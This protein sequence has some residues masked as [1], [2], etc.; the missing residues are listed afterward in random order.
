MKNSDEPNPT[1]GPRALVVTVALSSAGGAAALISATGITTEAGQLSRGAF[2][3]GLYLALG[4]ISGAL[5]IPFA[6]R[7]AHRFGTRQVVLGLWSML[8]AIWIIAG[9]LVAAGA[10]AMWVV[11]M[12]APLIGAT[13]AAGG[14]LSTIVY[15]AYLGNGDFATVVARMTFWRGVGWG[16]GA[17]AGGYF[18]NAGSEG[19]GLIAAGLIKV[20]L[21]IVLLRRT[22]A[23]ALPTPERPKAPWTEIR[24]A[25]AESPALRRTAVMG[26]S[27]A[28]FAAPAMT[29]TVPIAQSL[30][31][32][33]LYQGAGILMAGFAVG[34]LLSPALVARLPHHGR[35]LLFGARTGAA[36]GGL[37]IVL[38]LVS[39]MFSFR[40]EL[41]LWAV[42]AIGIGAF[43][44][45]SKAFSQSS[46]ANSR[47]LE[48]SASS[49]AAATFIAGLAGPVGV[50]GWSLALGSIGA[51]G[52]A[53][54]AGAALT[55][56][57]L[58]VVMMVSRESAT[59]SA[60]VD[61]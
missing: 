46:A 21:L 1:S 8:A 24:E 7:A 61:H 50:L 10:P 27:M 20:P 59:A 34:E 45:A 11:M 53:A 13:G 23:A 47:G 18:L 42:V 36:A 56:A 30:R 4:L 32:A 41:G 57:S 5:A 16:L 2:Y 38:G 35:P 6:P 37:L 52:T 14:V 17:L 19:L 25:F 29:L 33:P 15:R 39:G 60:A 28:L 31:H 48:R 51:E 9:A 54:I 3:S 22:P 44:F 49:L 40:T 55:L 12:I 58:V 43:R 26:V